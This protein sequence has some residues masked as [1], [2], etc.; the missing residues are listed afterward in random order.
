VKAAVRLL[1][2]PL[3][4]GISYELIRFTAKFPRSPWVKPLLWPGLAF[5]L[6]TT[7]EPDDAMLEVALK[8]LEEARDV[9]AEP[10]AA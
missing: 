10:A 4:A 9:A 8:A 5:Q 2:L 6:L 7:R 3:I 1:F